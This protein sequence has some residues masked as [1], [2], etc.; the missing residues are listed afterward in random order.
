MLFD[1]GLALFCYLALKIIPFLCDIVL[2]AIV[3][4]KLHLCMFAIDSYCSHRTA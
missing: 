2:Q 1:L 3:Y 4:E